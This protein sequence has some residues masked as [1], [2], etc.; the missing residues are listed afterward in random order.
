MGQLLRFQACR[1]LIDQVFKGQALTLALRDA[2]L[3][4][5][6]PRKQELNPV[7]FKAV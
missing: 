7:G 1:K 5:L 2:A 4:Q 6:S 3:W